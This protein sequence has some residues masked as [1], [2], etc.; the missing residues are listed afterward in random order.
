MLLLEQGGDR[1]GEAPSSVAANAFQVMPGRGSSLPIAGNGTA[2]RLPP[3]LYPPSGLLSP[4][5]ERFEGNQSL[6]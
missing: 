2:V 3:S 1:E 5:L 4:A 6:D